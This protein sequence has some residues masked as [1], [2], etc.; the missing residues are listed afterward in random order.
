MSIIVKD[1]Q[2]GIYKMYT[3]GA[4]NVIKERLKNI[5]FK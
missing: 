1:M 4:D 5:Y 2:D 3:K